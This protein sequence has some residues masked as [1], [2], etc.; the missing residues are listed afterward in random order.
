MK[1]TNLKDANLE[2]SIKS[3]HLNALSKCMQTDNL[4]DLTMEMDNISNNLCSI[5]DLASCLR[6]TNLNGKLGYEIFNKYHHL[7]QNLDKKRDL[8]LHVKNIFLSSRENDEKDSTNHL[9]KDQLTVIKSFLNDFEIHGAELQ[10]LK[11]REKA[12]QKIEEIRQLEYKLFKSNQTGLER[13]KAIHN[14]LSKRQKYAKS[15]GFES[16][17]HFAFKTGRQLITDH[18]EISRKS[19]LDSLEVDL[20]RPFP[21][22]VPKHIRIELSHALNAI[23]DFFQHEFNIKIKKSEFDD[24]F[25]IA[26]N[27]DKNRGGKESVIGYL[28]LNFEIRKGKSQI[29]PSHF[30][31]LSRKEDSHN[32]LY[33]IEND[34]QV[35]IVVI[36]LDKNPAMSTIN[37]SQ[38]LSLAHELGHALHSF[39]NTGRYH[40]TSSTRCP[41]DVAEIASEYMEHVI[42]HTDKIKL[43]VNTDEWKRFVIQDNMAEDKLNLWFS[44]LDLTLHSRPGDSFEA[45]LETTSRLMTSMDPISVITKYSKML[46]YYGSGFYVY[47]LAREIVNHMMNNDLKKEFIESIKTN[48]FTKLYYKTFEMKERSK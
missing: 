28:Y 48:D 37:F 35:P 3:Y 6:H 20:N 27:G 9:V 11:D 2:E 36:S 25:F 34:L 26:E 22:K 1:M 23:W 47:P 8:Y 16:Y 21:Q 45:M 14:L 30:L 10:D 12:W 31:L 19:F 43:P 38:Y 4:Q 13:A 44:K 15:L 40:N 32:I 42:L 18:E 33:N 41:L 24:N 29:P 17:L 46:V 39:I 5:L 7:M